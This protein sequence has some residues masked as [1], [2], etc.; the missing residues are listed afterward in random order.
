MAKD[1]YYRVLRGQRGQAAKDEL[2]KYFQG[3][4]DSAPKTGTPKDR[5]KL[6]LA[7]IMPFGIT[8]NTT[9]RLVASYLADVPADLKSAIGE[10]RTQTDLGGN[11]ALQIKK[12]KAA[13][14]SAS[15]GLTANG[16]YKKSKVTG[17]NYISYGGKA[18][19]YPMGRG[20]ANETINTAFS[21]VKA[22]LL[23]GNT[24][25]RVHLI[26]ESF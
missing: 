25:S 18:H 21:A 6:M 13:R 15:E 3:L 22:L 19:S 23:T 11:T 17:L 10:T 14:V 16:A 5:P 4:K 20:A 12:V 24:L 8:F 2:I 9:Q 26:K 1:R 7:Y